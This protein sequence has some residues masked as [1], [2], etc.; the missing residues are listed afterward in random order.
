MSSDL[1]PKKSLHAFLI[2]A[3]KDPRLV[4]ILIDSLQPLG[5]VYLHIDAKPVAEFARILKR[6][7]IFVSNSVNVKWGHWT[8]VEATLILINRALTDGASRLTL[9]TGDSLPIASS[10]KFMNLLKSD[11]DICHNRALKD[12]TDPRRDDQ[13]FRRYFAAKKYESF[14]PR[15]INLFLRKW[16]I[17]INIKK[18][19]QPLELQIGSAYWSVTSETMRKALDYCE[20]NPQLPTYFKKIKFPDETFFQTLFRF[21]SNNVNGTGIMYANWDQPNAPHPSPLSASILKDEFNKGNFYFARK[22]CSEESELF[23]TWSSLYDF[24]ITD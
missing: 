10:E 21:F 1:I 13:Y 15:L 7:D 22:F 14:F 23:T 6:E 2:L 5:R 17:R 16:P 24:K 8:M 9:I 11:V 19:L 18:Y 20:R 12:S 4:E 3:H